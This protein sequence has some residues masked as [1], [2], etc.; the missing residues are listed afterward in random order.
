[1]VDHRDD[2]V[3]DRDELGRPR[4][5]YTPPGSGSGLML[6][7]GAL[8]ALGLIFTFSYWEPSTT[9]TKTTMNQQTNPPPVI[10]PAPAPAPAPQVTPPPAPEQNNAPKQP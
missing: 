1:M 3:T 5:D 10:Q 6:I 8:A 4:E 7:I 2:F 9:G